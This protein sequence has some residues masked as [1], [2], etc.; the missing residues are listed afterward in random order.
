MNQSA[1]ASGTRRRVGIVLLIED[2]PTLVSTIEALLDDEGYS[3]HTAGSVA[4]ARER[5]EA[6]QP[7]VAVLD[8]TL[9][10]GFAE[11][12]L[13]DL[14]AA[15]VPTVIVSTFP[16]ARLIAARH[17][18]ELIPKPF[19]LTNLLEGIERARR[20]PAAARTA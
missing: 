8:L 19:D 18:V 7:D 15:Q 1:Q 12:L 10:D 2:N 3:T 13:A 9:S 5:L 20:K 17:S 16:L 14:A 4:G 11:E 6:I